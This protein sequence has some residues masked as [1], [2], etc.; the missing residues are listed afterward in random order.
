MADIVYD[1]FK[2]EEITD[3]S[4]KFINLKGL[5]HFWTNA[6]AYVDAQDSKLSGRID[7]VAG[8]LADLA[9]VVGELTGEGS[10]GTSIADRIQAAIDALKL[11]ETYETK[12]DATDK[13]TEAKGYTDTAV[14]EMSFTLSGKMDSDIAAAKNEAAANLATAVGAYA[15]EGD[16]PVEGSGLRN[17]IAVRDAAVLTAA[18]DYVDDVISGDDGLVKRV[19]DLEKIDHDKLAADASAAA[20]ATVLDGAPEKFDTLKEIAAWIADAD[21]AEDAA[22][23]VTRVSALEAADAAIRGEFATADADVL[24]AAKSHAETKAGEAQTAAI[25]ATNELLK[26]YTKTDDMNTAITAAENRAKQAASEAIAALTQ[27]VTDNLAEAKKYADD[28]DAALEAKIN[29]TIADKEAVTTQSLTDLDTRVKA[30]ATTI[31]D[32]TQTVAGNLAEAKQ[33]AETK[34]AEEAGKAQTTAEAF[35]KAYTDALFASITFATD[36]EIGGIFE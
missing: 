12:T 35:A 25:N 17:E 30:N 24:N 2:P 7:T 33:Y 29:K 10:Q 8:D 14:D 26:S 31:S 21:T 6:Q 22:S 34:A 11:D 18:K 27:T 36:T 3:G 9:A 13:L 23:L 28:Q 19:E 5:D 15:V 16:E 20:V 32:L 4:Q 1:F